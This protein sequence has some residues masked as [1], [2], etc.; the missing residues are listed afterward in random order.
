VSELSI[1][2]RSIL[3]VFWLKVPNATVTK[4]M[5]S[6]INPNAFTMPIT[7][8]RVGKISVPEYPPSLPDPKTAPLISP[9]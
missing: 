6:P 7:P 3:S 9:L 8:M 4:S 2:S 5:T 1:I